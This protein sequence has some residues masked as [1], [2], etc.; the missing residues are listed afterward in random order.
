[1]A[2]TLDGKQHEIE[3]DPDEEPT[4]LDENPKRCRRKE[5]KQDLDTTMTQIG[6]RKATQKRKQ[7]PATKTSTLM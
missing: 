5:T 1:L 3:E 6:R 2:Q 7:Q 4:I